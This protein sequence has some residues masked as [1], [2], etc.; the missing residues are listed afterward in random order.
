MPIGIGLGVLGIGS[1]GSALIG[2]NAANSAA[3]QSA[4]VLREAMQLSAGVQRQ[5]FMDTMRL[6]MPRAIAGNA[7]LARMMQMVGLDV[8]EQLYNG[9][10]FA[11]VFNG[12]GIDNLLSGA[13]SFNPYSAY[14]A[15]NPDVNAEYQRIIGEG[16]SFGGYIDET[17]DANADGQLDPGEYGRWHW[18]NFGGQE[19]RMLPTA[20]GSGGGADASDFAF[21]LS[22]LGDIGD[23]IRSTPGY[24]FRYNE[25]MRGVDAQY[26]GRGNVISG[27]AMQDLGNT[28]DNQIAYTEYQAYWNRLAQIA[29]VGGQSTDSIINVGTN[30]ANQ[31][32]NSI[33][34]WGAGT[35]SSYNQA[36]STVAGLWSGVGDAFGVAG[37]VIAANPW[38]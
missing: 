5:N 32:S 19:G 31:T 2:A 17:Y 21:E 4:A 18:D 11:A 35:A 8:P 25:A 14:I 1:V 12:S 27:A 3:D 20:P 23:I 10:N 34:Q 36:G 24:D 16:G 26:A 33:N 13:G 15:E 38:G 22:P 7:A 29:G 37:G 28:L 30:A 6:Q 9:E